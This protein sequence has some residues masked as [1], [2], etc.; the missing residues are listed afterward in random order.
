LAARQVAVFS[1]IHSPRVPE[2]YGAS[3]RFDDAF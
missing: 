3:R 1:L 2:T